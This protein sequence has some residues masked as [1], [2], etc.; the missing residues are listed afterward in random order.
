MPFCLALSIIKLGSR[1]K[2]SNPG[3]GV[4]PPLHLGV[5]AIEK[6]AFESASTKVANFTYLYF[7]IYI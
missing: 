4:A 1:V 2:L 6:E 3:K 5:V 7:K